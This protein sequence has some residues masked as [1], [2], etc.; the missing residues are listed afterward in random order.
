MNTKEKMIEALFKKHN[1]VAPK[2]EQNIVNAMYDF[3][4]IMIEEQREEM[5]RRLNMRNVPRP[6]L[7]PPYMQYFEP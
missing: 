7:E 1:I 4:K 6:D 3:A 5:S 2:Y